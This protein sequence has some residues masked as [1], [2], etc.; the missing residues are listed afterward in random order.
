VRTFAHQYVFVK[1]S[2]KSSD[3]FHESN[4][5]DGRYGATSLPRV[6]VPPIDLSGG[7]PGSPTRFAAPARTV[8]GHG[9]DVQLIRLREDVGAT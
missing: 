4:D 1:T 2:N 9:I 8:L 5:E 6:S 7:R 3:E